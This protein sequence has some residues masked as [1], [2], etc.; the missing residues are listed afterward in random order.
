MSEIKTAAPK[1]VVDKKLWNKIEK[2]VREYGKYKGDK[3][4][5]VISRAYQKAGGT[6][7]H[8]SKKASATEDLLALAERLE[9]KYIQSIS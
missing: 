4:F 2:H 5:E 3:M 9:E 7:T 1:F 8:K 6:F